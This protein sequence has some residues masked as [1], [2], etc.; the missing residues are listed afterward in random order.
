MGRYRSNL[1]SISRCRLSSGRVSFILLAIFP[2][3]SKTL[4]RPVRVNNCTPYADLRGFKTFGENRPAPVQRLEQRNVDFKTHDALLEEVS[5]LQ[6]LLVPLGH[7]KAH[8][9]FFT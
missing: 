9:A 4:L 3:P 8:V 2:Q 5:I 7:F 6:K 1:P